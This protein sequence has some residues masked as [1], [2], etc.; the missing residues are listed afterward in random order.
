MV[1]VLNCYINNKL[2]SSFVEHVYKYNY[3][4]YYFNINI[5]Y[6]KMGEKKKCQK[7]MIKRFYGIP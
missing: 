4:L 5:K 6:L 1:G 7:E 3:I 2:K